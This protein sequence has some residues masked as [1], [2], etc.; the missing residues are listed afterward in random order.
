MTGAA[1]TNSGLSLS[2]IPAVAGMMDLRG[3]AKVLESLPVTDHGRKFS[4]EIAIFNGEL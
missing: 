4:R 1:K 3:L 2:I